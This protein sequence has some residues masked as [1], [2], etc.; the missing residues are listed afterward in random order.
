VSIIRPMA[1]S[2]F[3]RIVQQLQTKVNSSIR[4]MGRCE[5]VP[6]RLPRDSWDLVVIELLVL[7]LSVTKW[8]T[9]WVCPIW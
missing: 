2:A 6:M 3:G 7:E 9:C 4:Q 5:L 1:L 8:A